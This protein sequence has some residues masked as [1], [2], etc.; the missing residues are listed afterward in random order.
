MT[1][2]VLSGVAAGLEQTGSMRRQMKVKRLTLYQMEKLKEDR[3]VWNMY[4]WRVK[5]Q[6]CVTTKSTESLLMVWQPGQ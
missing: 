6:Y 3:N 1:K 2:G 4:V 5:L